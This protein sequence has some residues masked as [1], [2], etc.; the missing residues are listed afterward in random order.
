MAL[1]LGVVVGQVGT[2]AKI[3]NATIDDAQIVYD[4]VRTVDRDIQELQNA[5]LIAKE[6]GPGGQAFLL[7]DEELTNKLEALSLQMPDLQK[8]YA[9]NLYNMPDNVVANTLTFLTEADLLYKQVKEHVRKA[10]TEAKALAAGQQRLQKFGLPTRYGVVVDIAKGD[11]AKVAPVKALFVEL[12]D[13]IC[14]DGKPHPEGCGSEPPT[15]FLYRPAELGPWGR[16]QLAT[17]AGKAIPAG[18]LIPLGFDPSPALEALF[19]GGEATVAEV[20]YMN[21]IK[22]ID[23]K[24]EDLLTRGKDLEK[25]LESVAATGKRFTFF[26]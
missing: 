8:V 12:G 14:A 23:A 21:R 15:G 17:P 9:S 11:D 2:K 24:V 4:A 18:R 10:K 1:I 25:K 20:A 26:L 3:F 13:P 5:L 22:D 16:K 6:R 19:K 7:G